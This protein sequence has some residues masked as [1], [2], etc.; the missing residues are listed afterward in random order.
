MD[1]PKKTS[2]I[3]EAHKIVEAKNGAITEEDEN[4]IKE[5]MRIPNDE[6][7]IESVTFKNY[8]YYF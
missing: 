8:N 6:I 3:A 1:K 4:S 5:S 7:S 2:W